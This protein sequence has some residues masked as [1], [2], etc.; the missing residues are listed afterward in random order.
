MGKEREHL[1]SGGLVSYKV[2]AQQGSTSILHYYT[3]AIKVCN[4]HSENPFNISSVV[5][6]QSDKKLP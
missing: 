2:H 3:I 4:L 1:I 6:T 5:L